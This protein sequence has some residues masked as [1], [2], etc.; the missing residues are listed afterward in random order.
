MV[1]A[2]C[3]KDFGPEKPPTQTQQSL[4]TS[5]ASMFAEFM[6]ATIDPD[7][8]GSLVNSV[9]AIVNASY[10]PTAKQL[11]PLGAYAACATVTPTRVDFNCTVNNATLTGSVTRTPNGSGANWQVD[12]SSATAQQST[13]QSISQ[14]MHLTGGVSWDGGSKVNGTLAMNGS[15]NITNP[16]GPSESVT[17]SSS[18]AANQLVIDSTQHCATGGNVVVDMEADTSGQS[19]SQAVRYTFTACNMVTVAVAN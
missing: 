5:S 18:V 4:A 8:F 17:M 2:G 12:L 19:V 3:G 1:L 16:G 15:V 13:P 7:I 14:N 6:V 10:V 9:F 11:G